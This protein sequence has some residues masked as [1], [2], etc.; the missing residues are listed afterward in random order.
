M[1][2]NMDRVIYFNDK[3]DCSGKK[4]FDFID[5]AFSKADCFMLVYANY[6]G[7]GYTKVMKNFM[8]LLKPY[9]IKI[10][11]N[12]SWPGTS[13]TKSLNTKYKV[14][15]Y[16]NTPEAKAVLKKV[17][18]LWSWSRP[19]YPQDL[20][21]F[22]GNQCWF[23]SIAHE[24]IGAI[25]HASKSDIEFVYG[26]NMALKETTCLPTNDFFVSMMRI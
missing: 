10:R 1:E 15:F 3:D 24:R 7:K 26:I 16:R 5:Y 13:N 4:Y 22:I 23:Y 2:I 6:Y 11:T 8:K 17:E 12:P 20:A 18:S 19:S 9:I 14:V 21:F 25:I